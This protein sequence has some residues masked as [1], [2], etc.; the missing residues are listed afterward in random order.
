[1]D[2]DGFTMECAAA[3]RLRQDLTGVVLPEGLY[4]GEYNGAFGFRI[5]GFR[6]DDRFNTLSVAYPPDATFRGEVVLETMLMRICPG[7]QESV[8]IPEFD[9]TDV[10]RWSGTAELLREI[11]RLADP[12]RRRIQDDEEEEVDDRQEVP[13]VPPEYSE[14]L[15]ASDDPPSYDGLAASADPPPYES[16][17]ASAELRGA[18]IRGAEIRGAEIRGAEIRVPEL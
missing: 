1:M 2:W 5:H 16:L 4:L 3:R 17:A 14:R 15:A 10:C 11:E 7:G 6:G 8:Y 13:V 12:A 9:Y 18:E